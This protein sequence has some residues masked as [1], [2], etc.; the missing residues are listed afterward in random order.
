M[1]KSNVIIYTLDEFKALCDKVFGGTVWI[2]CESGKWFWII[3]SEELDE[4][5]I[6]DKIE[7]ELI[8]ELN[9]FL[10]KIY[11]D[12]TNDVVIISYN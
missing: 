10:D 11:V 3:M 4:N 2:E 7:V 6:M 9:R 8:V 12:A 5:T 1:K